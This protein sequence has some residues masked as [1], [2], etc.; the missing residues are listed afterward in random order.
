MSDAK[1][2]GCLLSA[3]IL[4]PLALTFVGFYDEDWRTLQLLNCQTEAL[5]SLA[6]LTV[7]GLLIRNLFCFAILNA[8][9]ERLRLLL[10]G[11]PFELFCDILAEPYFFTRPIF[12][13]FTLLFFRLFAWLLLEHFA[14][15]SLLSYT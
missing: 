3:L 2:L 10:K 1:L 8:H 13:I 5:Q 7:R 9:R 6:R 11:Q 15:A 4:Q 12:F 14:E